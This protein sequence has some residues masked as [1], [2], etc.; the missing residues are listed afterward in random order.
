MS[1]ADSG[2]RTYVFWYHFNKNAWRTRNAI[3]WT[4]HWKGVCYIVDTITCKVPTYSCERKK[5]PV[6]IIK[7]K[8]RVLEIQHTN[9]KVEAILT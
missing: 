5:Q 6:A 7:G 9:G 2:N 1:T 8:A 4:V 3:S